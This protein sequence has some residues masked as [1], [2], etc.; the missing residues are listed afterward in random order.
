VEITN[1]SNANTDFIFKNKLLVTD[2]IQIGQFKFERN[3]IID[4]MNPNE[5]IYL[6]QSKIENVPNYFHDFKITENYIM[7]PLNQNLIYKFKNISNGSLFITKNSNPFKSSVGDYKITYFQME[8]NNQISILGA[9][10]GDKIIPKKYM[11]GSNGSDTLIIKNSIMDFVTFMN[12][13]KKDMEN[14]YF[15]VDVICFIL[16]FGGAIL[17]LFSK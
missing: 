9:K 2:Y 11:E 15:I 4:Y 10:K 16:I 14:S 3:N 1:N 8:N 17:F 6:T 7:L 5:K 12:E 13:L